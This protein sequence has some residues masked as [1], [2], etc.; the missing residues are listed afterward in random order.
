MLS[1]FA[2][3]HGYGMNL[4][5]E[6]AS[7]PKVP[8][9]RTKMLDAYSIHVNITYCHLASFAHVNTL[10]SSGDAGPAFKSPKVPVLYCTAN[11]SLRNWSVG[12]CR[13]AVGIGAKEHVQQRLR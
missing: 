3:V 10:E 9:G 11:F 13:S 2:S 1:L 7:E 4:F 5:R 6:N 8:E 12:L